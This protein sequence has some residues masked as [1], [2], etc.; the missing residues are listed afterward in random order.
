MLGTRWKNGFVLVGLALGASACP[1]GSHGISNTANGD[2]GYVDFRWVCTGQGDLAC[3]PDWEDEFSRAVALGSR[4]DADFLLTT[5]LPS[6]LDRG[7][8]LLSSA[9]VARSIGGDFEALEEGRFTLMALT[10]DD[11]V[12]DF[13]AVEVRAVDSLR[14]VRGCSTNSS[15]CG[16]LVGEEQALGEAFDVRVEPYGGDDPLVGDLDGYAW[17]SLTPGRV[18]ISRS[19][20]N[21]ARLHVVAPG[22]ATVEVRLGEISAQL[23][24]SIV[25]ND[26]DEIDPSGPRR[27]RPGETGGETEGETEGG[28]T[29]GETEGETETDTDAGTGTST[30]GGME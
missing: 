17:E 14:I 30:T 22:P 26:E 8:L 4:F 23:H 15:S 9:G 21:G 2:L 11:A 29:G 6:E 13:A 3:E 18:E 24:F 25:S 12:A 28:S 5:R 10:S 1:D 7:A 20:G 27:T 19:A 16:R